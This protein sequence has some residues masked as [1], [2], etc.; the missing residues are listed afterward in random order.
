[1]N[2]SYRIITSADQG[3]LAEALTQAM[4]DEWEPLGGVTSA[5]MPHSDG[6][7]GEILYSQA[8]IRRTP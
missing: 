7:G 8:I 5:W 3:E 4:A 6:V 2:E 1:M